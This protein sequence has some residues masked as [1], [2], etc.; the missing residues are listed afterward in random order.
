[1]FAGENNDRD[2]TRLFSFWRPA[3]ESGPLKL[4]R[5][6]LFEYGQTRDKIMLACHSTPYLP[7]LAVTVEGPV[8]FQIE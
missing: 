6:V 1:M 8:M 7:T 2:W 4:I 3:G 5:A